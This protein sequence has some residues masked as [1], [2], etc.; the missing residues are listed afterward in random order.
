MKAQ[1]RMPFDLTDVPRVA[2]E[3][4]ALAMRLMIESERAS[5]LFRGA[6]KAD[7][8]PIE[9]AF[10]REFRG[11]TATG[12]A[13]LMR[14]WALVDV[15]QS[16]RLNGLLLARGY[17]LLA[18]AATAAARLRLNIDW[19]F[20]PVQVEWAIGTAA[21]VVVAFP[22]RASGGAQLEDADLAA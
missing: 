22:H 18:P 3:D 13:A 16:R 9:A 1:T 10:W 5:L 12:V 15:F 7:R 4:L 8:A 17:A 2:H 11:E 14:F 6:G 20:N 19:G 21:P